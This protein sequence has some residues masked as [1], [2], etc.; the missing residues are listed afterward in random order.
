[1][2]HLQAIHRY[3][4][5]MG[6]ATAP[7]RSTRNRNSQTPTDDIERPS[8]MTSGPAPKSTPP[9]TLPT[10][11]DTNPESDTDGECRS[12]SSSIPTT[13]DPKCAANTIATQ[14]DQKVR[15][16][17]SREKVIP[18]RVPRYSKTESSRLSAVKRKRF[19]AISSSTRPNS[20]DHTTKCILR[21]RSPPCSRLM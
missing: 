12:N 8:S 10:H 13:S 19:S 4:E 21:V 17:T 15:D 11:V 6:N 5:A 9:M 1:M 2:V 3:S 7:N 16:D 14:S 18:V 20:S